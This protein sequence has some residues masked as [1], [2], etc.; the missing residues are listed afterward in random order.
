MGKGAVE[1]K[2]LIRDKNKKN[3][4][5]HEGKVEYSAILSECQDFLNEKT[6]L[7][8]LGEQLGVVVDRSTKSH[9]ELAGEG[10]E[11]TWGRAKGVYQKARLADKKGKDNFQKQ[12]SHCLS[13]QKG[14]GGGS[15]S[16]R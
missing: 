5:N 15:F 12:V 11:Y 1:S 2:C 13:T 16:R 9:P 7:I 3:D 6:C 4:P 8:F 10:I 14:A